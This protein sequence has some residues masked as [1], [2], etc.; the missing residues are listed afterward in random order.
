MCKQTQFKSKHIVN[1]KMHRPMQNFRGITLRLQL[2][3]DDQ[4]RERKQIC[5]R[6]LRTR[7]TKAAQR[8]RATNK[9]TPETMLT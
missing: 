7:P 8:N 3:V 1:S 6:I 5:R 2:F 4:E 9:Q